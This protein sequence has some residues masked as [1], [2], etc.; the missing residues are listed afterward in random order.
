[1]A[2]VYQIEITRGHGR[3]MSYVVRS[4]RINGYVLWNKSDMNTRG[5]V[6]SSFDMN[7][8]KNGRGFD[9]AAHNKRVKREYGK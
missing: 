6:S 1:M 5:I 4:C 7:T 2:K 9:R 3:R 8:P